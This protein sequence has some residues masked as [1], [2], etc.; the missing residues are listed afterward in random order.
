MRTHSHK[1]ISVSDF[2]SL[3]I[4]SVNHILRNKI[5]VIHNNSQRRHPSFSRA[6]S[7][8][9]LARCHNYSRVTVASKILEGIT[10]SRADL[11]SSF[12]KKCKI[13]YIRTIARTYSRKCE[14]SNWTNMNAL[15]IY[16]FLYEFF[17]FSI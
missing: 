13:L 2:F 8:L 1:F 10:Q 7:F 14:N 9:K 12:T 5:R 11:K 15:K 6:R 3:K 17:F 16:F 4:N